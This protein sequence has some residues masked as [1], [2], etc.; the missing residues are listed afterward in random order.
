M[1]GLVT[2]A[3]ADR[4]E[5]DGAS[6]WRAAAAGSWTVDDEWLLLTVVRGRAVATVADALVVRPDVLAS[7]TGSLPFLPSVT[8]DSVWRG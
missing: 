5:F 8:V 3:A 6:G 1:T 4:D 7:L 2:A